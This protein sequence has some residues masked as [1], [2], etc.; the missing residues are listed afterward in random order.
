M[1]I[2]KIIENE[3]FIKPRLEINESLDDY[4]FYCFNGEPKY[5]QVIRDR[6]SKETIDFYDMEWIHQDFVGLNPVNHKGQLHEI[7]NGLTP[8]S[9][10]AHLKIMISICRKLAKDIPFVRVDLYMIDN[11][12]YFGELTFYPATGICVFS[13]REWAEKLGELLKLP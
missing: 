7:R 9:C 2:I 12:A 11:K 6:Y 13:P 3:I 10:P 5:C 4:K 1:G 8:V